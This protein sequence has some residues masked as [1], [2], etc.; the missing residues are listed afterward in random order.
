MELTQM[1][2]NPPADVRLHAGTAGVSPASSRG[3]SPR[4]GMGGETPPELAGEDAC[5]APALG[6]SARRV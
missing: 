6:P 4:V 2:G 3:V 1:R 5:G